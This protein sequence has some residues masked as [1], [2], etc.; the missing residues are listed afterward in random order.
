MPGLSVG[1]SSL[2]A[3]L[4]RLRPLRRGRESADDGFKATQVS[5]T[6]RV[7]H[8]GFELVHHPRKVARLTFA[9][10]REA[11]GER[12]AVRSVQLS[13]NEA[14]FL[15]PIKHVGQGGTFRPKLAMQGCDRCGTAARELDEDARLSLRDPEPAGRMLDI[16]P[17]QVGGA[18]K[19]CQT[20]HPYRILRYRMDA[21]VTQDELVAAFEDILMA[22]VGET[23][24]VV[25]GAG[26]RDTAFVDRVDRVS[27]DC[28]FVS[29]E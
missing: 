3:N 22:R 28:E 15:E 4:R 1:A 20:F 2:R 12:A 27:G 11:N 21:H 29:R 25:C 7:A 13:S 26:K 17:D 5:L 10:A 16:D 23:D 14:A 18:F 9:A 6:D 24:E 19:A 8:I